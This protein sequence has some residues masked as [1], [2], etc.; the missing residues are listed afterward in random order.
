[1]RRIAVI[2]ASAVAVLGLTV[3][4]ADAATNHPVTA[5]IKGAKVTGYWHWAKDSKGKTRRWLHTTI[6]DTAK[7]GKSAAICFTT[8]STK[9]KPSSSYRCGIDT[10]GAG[11]SLLIAGWADFGHFWYGAATVKGSTIRTLSGI[12]KAW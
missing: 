9:P 3:G 2:A 12:K 6:T 1:M 8:G 7:D 10:K 4:T 5:S 11:K